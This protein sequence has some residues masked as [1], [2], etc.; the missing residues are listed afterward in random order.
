MVLPSYLGGEE[1]RQQAAMLLRA[2]ARPGTASR[3]LR[4]HCSAVVIS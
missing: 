2:A 1:A 3:A 4:Y